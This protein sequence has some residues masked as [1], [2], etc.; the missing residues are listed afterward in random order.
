MADQQ[1]GFQSPGAPQAIQD[2][3]ENFILY[4]F[5]GF[6]GLNTKAA[7]PA[8][9]DQEYSYA[10]NMMPLGP[11][12]FRTMYD[13]GPA[14]Y[15][16][17]SGAGVAFFNFGNIGDTAFAMVFT[18]DGGITQVNTLTDSSTFVAPASTILNTSANIGMAQWGSQYII[19][20]APQTN[21]YF[22][23]DGVV[24]Y[25]AG[26]IG[27]TVIVTNDGQGYKSK[28]TIN[29]VG[30]EGTGATFASTLTSAGNLSQITV[31]NPGSGYQASDYVV[32]AFSGGGNG[33]PATAIATAVLNSSN[34]VAV[35]NVITGG[36]GYNQSTVAV[37]LLGGGGIGATATATVSVSGGPVASIAVITPG[38]AFITAPTVVITDTSNPVVQANIPIMP[39]GVQGTA[40]ETYAGRVWVTNGAAPTTPP[41]K[42]LTV[43][44]APNSPADFNVSD[45]AG[46]Y[47]DTNSFA[48]VG[49]HALRQSNGF[50]YEIGDSSVDYISGVNT[51]GSPPITTFSN[52]NVDPQIGSPWPNTVQVFS[53]SIVFANTFGVHAMYGGAV[54]KVSTPLD[55]IYTTVTP[56]TPSGASAPTFSGLQPSGA[57]AIIF[58]IHVYIVLMP[59]IDPFTGEQRNALMC[60][61]G[62]KW[63]LAQESVAFKQ[64][65]S[66]EINSILTAY[67]TDGRAI[68]PLFQ[69]PS[70]AIAKVVQSKQWTAPHYIMRKRAQR[71]AGLIKSNDVMDAFTISIDTENGSVNIPIVNPFSVQWVNNQNQVVQ[72]VNNLGQIVQWQSI[73]TEFF[74][75]QA[76]T[77]GDASG[78]IMGLTFQTTSTDLTLISLAIIAQQYR[79]MW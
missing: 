20:C 6:T 16:A 69:T 23:W 71:V 37:S 62:Q 75:D 67:G 42:N 3:P 57:V 56:Q 48:R 1:Q 28:P 31:V 61:D 33:T 64:I 52:Q 45:G 22:I 77:A 51:S 50:L 36:S 63:W 19:M 60:W 11:N 5:D 73:G 25:Q 59:I 14:L 12:N 54:Q 18:S 44:S 21:G 2:F 46:S 27:P 68:Y 15:T 32:L 39:F 38:Q 8:I 7:R 4:G 47:L 13:V 76:L 66:Q 9:G 34:G 70:N 41:A 49:Y 26:T 35:I 78:V 30:G 24:F 10:N 40:I 74:I 29:A 65:A 58:G 17:A 55:G 72:W 43:F 53:R 79:P